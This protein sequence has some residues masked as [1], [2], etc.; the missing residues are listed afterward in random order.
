MVYPI[1][2]QLSDLPV[3]DKV[4]GAMKAL[5]FGR[6]DGRF[7]GFVGGFGRLRRVLGRSGWL[8]WVDGCVLGRGELG[9]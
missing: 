5:G 3:N 4:K 8:R 1:L 2:D 9:S 6:L 7:D